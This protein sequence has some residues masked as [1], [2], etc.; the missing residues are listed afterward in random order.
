MKRTINCVALCLA[1]PVMGFACL[2]DNELKITETYGAPAD[3][4]KISDNL[5]E[6]HYRVKDMK[7]TVTFLNGTS[8]CEIFMRLDG[9]VLTEEQIQAILAS[10]SNHLSWTAKES[11]QTSAKEWTIAGLPPS[12]PASSSTDPTAIVMTDRHRS[13]SG[14]RMLAIDIINPNDDAASSAPLAPPV[15]RRAICRGTA[16]NSV[17]VVFTSAFEQAAKAEKRRGN[18][19]LSG[20]GK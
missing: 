10:N 12:S 13:V 16:T 5:V 18:S 14:A 1:L 4:K 11:A 7:V 20:S 2:G 15:L 8:Q 17:M 6:R 19:S 3:E 9:A